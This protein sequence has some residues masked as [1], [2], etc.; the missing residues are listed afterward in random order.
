M[1]SENHDMKIEIEFIAICTADQVELMRIRLICEVRN[2]LEG[3]IIERMSFGPIARWYVKLSVSFS[4]H[5][6]ITSKEVRAW[7]KPLD[8]VLIKNI[9]FTH[10]P[11]VIAQGTL[12]K[13]SRHH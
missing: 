2:V 8:T 4:R 11:V 10:V 12:P 13:A 6:G 5:L 1:E 7:L 9:Y 3:P